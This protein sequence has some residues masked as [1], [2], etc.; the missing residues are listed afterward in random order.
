MCATTLCLLCP[1]LRRSDGDAEDDQAPAPPVEKPNFGLS[2][3]LAKDE[4]HGN[5]YRGVQLK[6]SEPADA[7]MPKRRWRL[8]V[9]KNDEMI[10]TRTLSGHAAFVVVDLLPLPTGKPLYLHRQSA[11]LVGRH[12]EVC[13]GEL[14][15]WRVQEQRL[16][17]VGVPYCRLLMYSPSMSHAPN[18]TPCFNFGSW[19]LLPR[20]M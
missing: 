4:R 3:A 20:R 14:H 19:W 13:Y 2:G 18:N 1:R 8:Y 17:R 5:M 7:C 6:W 15:V 9:F 10:G 11:Y 16:I 12:K